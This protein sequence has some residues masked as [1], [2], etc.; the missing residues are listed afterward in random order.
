MQ[1]RLFTGAQGG[2]LNGD[3]GID[4]I[5]ITFA[6]DVRR[7]RIGNLLTPFFEQLRFGARVFVERVFL[8]E[9]AINAREI[10]PPRRVATTRNGLGD[11]MPA[12]GDALLYAILGP[13]AGI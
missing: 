9:R 6:R 10:L 7:L 5:G 1:P 8:D 13:I 4:Q 12:Q 11:R 3:L 2:T